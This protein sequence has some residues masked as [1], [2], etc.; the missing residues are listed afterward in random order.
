MIQTLL[1]GGFGRHRLRLV[2]NQMPNRLD[3]TPDELEKMLSLP[4]YAMLPSDHASLYESY[5]EGKLLGPNSPLGKH[6]A[7]M[8]AKLAGIEEVKAKRKFSLFGN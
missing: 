6:L 4:V 8:T 7:R 1:D 5:S 3:V 2:L